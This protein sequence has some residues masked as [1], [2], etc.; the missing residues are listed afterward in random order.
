MSAGVPLASWKTQIFESLLG[1][2]PDW[3]Q[4]TVLALVVLAVLTSWVLKLKRRIA[5]RRALR[6]GAPVHAQGSGA[7]FLGPYA[8]RN[9]AGGTAHPGG[10]E[11]SGADFLGAY[12]PRR[13]DGGRG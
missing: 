5:A 13:E 6:A 10:R 11:P 7:D 1:F 3:V 4:I 8:P 9:Q 12:A 2:L